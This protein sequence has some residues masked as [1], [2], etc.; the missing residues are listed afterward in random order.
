MHNWSG[1]Y[2]N[3]NPRKKV[4]EELVEDPLRLKLQLEQEVKLAEHLQWF[5]VVKL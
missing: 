3:Q 1:N 2:D 4:T 5:L